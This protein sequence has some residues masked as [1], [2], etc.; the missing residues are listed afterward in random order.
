M[1]VTPASRAAWI[2]A[3]PWSWSGRPLIDSCIPPSPISDTV[4]SPMALVFMLSNVPRRA[5]PTRT[6]YASPGWGLA[7]TYE[8]ERCRGDLQ[9]RAAP[10]ARGDGPQADRGEDPR[11][12]GRRRDAG[13][14]REQR[15]PHPPARAERRRGPRRARG[16]TGRRAG[17]RPEGPV[18]LG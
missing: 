17:R 14:P 11:Q 13:R 7:S 2:V 10:P 15:R 16:R 4:R 12:R 5:A 6:R 3:T 18:T 9:P 8:L 1:R